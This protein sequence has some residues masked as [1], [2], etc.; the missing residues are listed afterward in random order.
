MLVPRPLLVS[1]MANKRTLFVIERQ[2]IST[3]IVLRLTNLL[4]SGSRSNWNLEVS[5]LVE[6]AKSRVPGEKSLEQG[7]E[8]LNPHMVSV[9]QESNS[10][11]NGGRRVLS[12]PRSPPRPSCS[13]QRVQIDLIN[14]VLLPATEAIA[15][16]FFFSFFFLLLLSLLL[17]VCLFVCLFKPETIL[18]LQKD[19]IC[20]ITEKV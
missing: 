7:R 2:W 12:R 18:R 13:L 1:N 9:Q 8:P 6:R 3:K 14:F 5:V 11:N 4:P 15:F 17:F 19:F 20:G 10:G 16:V